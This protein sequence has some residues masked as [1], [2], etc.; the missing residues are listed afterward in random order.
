M[1]FVN[2]RFLF[3]RFMAATYFVF[4]A[5]FSFAHNGLSGSLCHQ[6]FGHQS[7]NENISVAAEGQFVV[8]ALAEL[9]KQKFEVNISVQNVLDT[10]FNEAQF[11]TESRLFNEPAPVTELHFTPGTPFFLK[12]S[13]SYFF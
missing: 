8:D 9:K 13:V 7:T 4:A 5:H 10:A 3:I 2:T 12:G 11:D 1:Q 6:H